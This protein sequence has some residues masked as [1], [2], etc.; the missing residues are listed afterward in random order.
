MRVRDTE[1]TL[2]EISDVRKF[3]KAGKLSAAILPHIDQLAHS[4]FFEEPEEFF[5][6]FLRESNRVDSGAHQRGYQRPTRFGST[7]KAHSLA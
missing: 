6:G 3:R 4:S 1:Y 5:S 2:Q 7:R